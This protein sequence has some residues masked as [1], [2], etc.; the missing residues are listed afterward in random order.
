MGYR[1]IQVQVTTEELEQL[2]KIGKTGPRA[3]RKLITLGLKSKLTESPVDRFIE[4]CIVI[5]HNRKD[6]EALSV[7]YKTFQEY[8]KDKK[9][10]PCTKQQMRA[11]IEDKHNVA[12]SRLST[13]PHGFFGIQLL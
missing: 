11:V 3:L 6:Q 7:V 1:T 9:I 2:K 5:T 4:D 8:C 13:G 12:Y 10:T